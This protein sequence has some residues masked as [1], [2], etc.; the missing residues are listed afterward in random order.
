MEPFMSSKH[1]ALLL[2]LALLGLATP[3]SVLAEASP[4]AATAISVAST[5]A[6]CALGALLFVN[7]EPEAGWALTS[8]GVLLGPATGYLYGGLPGRGLAGIGLRAGS[9]LIGLMGV[10]ASLDE[11]DRSTGGA[12]LVMIGAAGLAA[13]AGLDLAVVGRDVRR[14]PRGAGVRLVPWRSPEGAPGFALRA[15]F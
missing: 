8:A 3:A 5:L 11:Y 4:R 13:S 15:R 9:S 12:V 7:D 6:P 1:R 2:P 14:R 10:G